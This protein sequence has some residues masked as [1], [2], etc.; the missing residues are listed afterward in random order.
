MQQPKLDSHKYCGTEYGTRHEDLATTLLQ[1]QKMQSEVL[2]YAIRNIVKK[3]TRLHNTECSH[4][5]FATEFSV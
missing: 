3:K 2:W 1:N 4:D 5:D